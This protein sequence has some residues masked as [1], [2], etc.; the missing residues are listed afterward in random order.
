[1]LIG[2]LEVLHLCD[3]YSDIFFSTQTLINIVFTAGTTFLL[4]SARTSVQPG[5]FDTQTA[6]KYFDQCSKTLQAMAWPSAKLLYDILKRMKQDWHP[7]AVAEPAPPPGPPSL[8]ELQDPNSEMFQYLTRMGWAPPTVAQQPAPPA[9]PPPPQP[10]VNFDM[11]LAQLFGGE[12]DGSVFD[13]ESRWSY[14]EG[15]VKD[16]ALTSSI[17]RMAIDSC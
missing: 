9:R 17:R 8:Q 16:G 12:S 5:A 15:L 2:S 4:L 13:R 3:L 11:Q 6:L 1:M 14:G 10:E 7:S